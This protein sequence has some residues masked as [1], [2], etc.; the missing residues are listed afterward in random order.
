MIKPNAVLVNITDSTG[1]RWNVVYIRAA[2]GSYSH[3]GQEYVKT[4]DPLNL[5]PFVNWLDCIPD[6]EWVHPVHA[7]SDGRGGWHLKA[8]DTYHEARWNDQSVSL[9]KLNEGGLVFHVFNKLLDSYKDM[10]NEELLNTL[11]IGRTNKITKEE[12][13]KI[14]QEN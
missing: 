14:Y 4:T 2:D 7:K 1:K 11:N 8:Y 6:K 5:D 10:T 12:F 3:A 9:Q 13:E